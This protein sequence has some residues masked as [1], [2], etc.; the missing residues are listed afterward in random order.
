[1]A[2]LTEDEQE[3]V[4]RLTRELKNRAEGGA[5]RALQLKLWG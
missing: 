1:M 2:K 3:Q 4:L 5:V